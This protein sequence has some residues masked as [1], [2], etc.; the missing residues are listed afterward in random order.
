MIVGRNEIIDED[1]ADAIQNS[2]IETVEVRSPLT[3]DL[4]HGVCALCYGRDLG[5]GDMVGIG[6]AVGIIAAQSIGEPGTQ[7]TLR[8]FHSG[9]T[10][11]SGGDITSGLPRVEE[12][13]EARR[14][15]KG[16]SVMTD[17]GGT[18]RLHEREDGARIAMVID[19]EVNNE[20]HVV[21]EDWEICVADGKDIA[22]GAVV[23]KNGEEDLKATLAGTVHI[24]DH[25]VYIR[26]ERRDE[27]EYEIPANARLRKTI[28]DG[29]TVQ[30]GV[31]LTEGSKNPHR[32]L[33]V[34]GAGR[35]AKVSSGRNPGSLS[36][37]GREHRRQAF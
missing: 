12:L 23:A 18:L 24:E 8:T 26:F 9:G 16:E 13:F 20:T 36:Q 17:V 3:C 6:S 28:Y 10:A 31:Q 14:M 22:V 2:T 1:I 37:P 29:M 34:L 25:T 11:K 35:H 33:R 21:P 15:P 30:P 4:I 7:L 27:H 19:S 5:T 32:I